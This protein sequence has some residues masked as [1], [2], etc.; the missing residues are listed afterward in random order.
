MAAPDKLART[1]GSLATHSHASL[2]APAARTRHRLPAE[3]RASRKI[4]FRSRTSVRGMM[5]VWIPAQALHRCVCF[6]S[7]LELIFITLAMTSGKVVDLLE[8]PQALNYRDASGK[9]R[10]H[11]FDFLI[12]M[13]DGQRHAVAVRPEERAIAKRFDAELALIGSQLPPDFAENVI[14]F[15]DRCFSA[16]DASNALRY[17][18]LLKCADPEADMT[19]QEA[20]QSLHRPVS[21][22]DLCAATGLAGRAYRAA[23][24]AVMSGMLRQVSPGLI[25]LNTVVAKEGAA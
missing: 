6:E 7:K 16:A 3:S 4:S 25:D 21:M 1:E 20:I 19:I 22:S 5:P 17:F 2:P 18:E 9:E 11:T 14:L 15:T 12:T 24:R 8:Q 10:S 13:H 23:F